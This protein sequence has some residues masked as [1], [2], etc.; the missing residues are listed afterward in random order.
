MAGAPSI[1]K[2]EHWTLVASDVERTR[3]WYVEVLGAQIPERIG[4]PCVTLAGTLIDMFPCGTDSPAGFPFGMPS[5]S[6][7]G[8]HH[9]YVISLDDYDA[10]IAHLDNLG[11]HYRRAAHG[12]GRMS[13][14]VDDPDG[15]HIE[16]TVPFDDLTQGRSEIEKRG[17]M[18]EALRPQRF[19]AR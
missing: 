4:P 9:A 13:I 16:L 12:M 1:Q 18:E 10:W 8:Q 19:D 6:S 17:L 11:Q 7:I 14:Y 5:P 3:R 15:Y 2:L